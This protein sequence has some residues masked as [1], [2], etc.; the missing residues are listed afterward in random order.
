MLISI[1]QLLGDSVM[2]LYCYEQFCDFSDTQENLCKQVKRSS[3]I[4]YVTGTKFR[5]PFN[6]FESLMKEK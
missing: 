5:C 4:L 6:F 1:N 3:F 2:N